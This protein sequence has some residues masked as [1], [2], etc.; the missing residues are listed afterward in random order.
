MHDMQV[1]ISDLLPSAGIEALPGSVEGD[2][3]R[4]REAVLAR[5]KEEKMNARKRFRTGR[6]LLIAAVVTVLLSAAA[7]AAAQGFSELS[8]RREAESRYR[9]EPRDIVEVAPEDSPLYMAFEELREFREELQSQ[10]P[11]G[12]LTQEEFDKVMEDNERISE[13]YVEL[14]EKYGLRPVKS[15]GSFSSL[16]GLVTA[17]NEFAAVHDS[18]FLPAEDPR[19]T[20]ISASYTDCGSFSYAGGFTLPGGG[21]ADYGIR[22]AA[23]GAMENLT[24]AIYLDEMEDWKY[25]AAD[26]TEVL[27]GLGERKALLYVELEHCYVMATIRAGSAGADEE[28]VISEFA[29][30]KGTHTAISREDLE[31]FADS[32]GF[33][34]IDALAASAQT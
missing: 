17:L 28:S 22:S 33:G 30:N 25:T 7:F 21:A 31:Y 24:E 3:E 1:I 20:V 26:G 10:Q 5:L 15:L 34:T 8:H 2:S 13:K 27:L 6:T 12:A 14:A 32:I 9:S 4:V 11:T 16:E 29:W 18:S 19:A 23:K